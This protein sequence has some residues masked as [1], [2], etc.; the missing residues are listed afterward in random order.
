LVRQLNNSIVCKQPLIINNKETAVKKCST[1]IDEECLEHTVKCVMD[2]CSKVPPL[3]SLRSWNNWNEYHTAAF[4]PHIFTQ[5]VFGTQSIDK[6]LSIDLDM[7]T[8]T[9]MLS[10]VAA[11]RIDHYKLFRASQQKKLGAKPVKLLTIA[12]SPSSTSKGLSN[13]TIPTLQSQGLEQYWWSDQMPGFAFSSSVITPLETTNNDNLLHPSYLTTPLG[14]FYGLVD[15]RKSCER[16][17]FQLLH[18]SVVKGY[19]RSLGSLSLWKATKGSSTPHRLRVRYSHRKVHLKSAHKA[20]FS[21]SD[22]SEAVTSSKP[23]LWG[24]CSR[25]SISSPPPFIFASSSR[26]KTTIS[27]N[28]KTCSLLFGTVELQNFLSYSLRQNQAKVQMNHQERFETNSLKVTSLIV[29]KILVSKR[30]C[31]SI[32]TAAKLPV[33]HDRQEA[34]LFVKRLKIPKS[35][36]VSFENESSRVQL[37]QLLDRKEDDGERICETSANNKRSSPE[38]D[39]TSSS[40]SNSQVEGTKKPRRQNDTEENNNQDL[41]LSG[42]VTVQDQSSAAAT[43]PAAAVVNEIPTVPSSTSSAIITQLAPLVDLLVDVSGEEEG[44]ELQ[45]EEEG[46]DDDSLASSWEAT[47]EGS[48]KE[49]VLTMIDNQGNSHKQLFHKSPPYIYD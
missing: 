46:M 19:L 15:I 30:N 28:N 35:S 39:S 37:Y 18:E 1:E 10:V 27:N 16:E 38:P 22:E 43:I 8:S 48:P 26:V 42:D 23:S 13:Y 24:S 29:S 49:P 44:A 4:L 25:N 7:K 41:S 47:E 40:S 31:S 17:A 3:S 32:F 33:L 14:R 9:R 34:S 21:D 11:K 5:N 36:L 45:N 2:V 20:L 12:T 6:T